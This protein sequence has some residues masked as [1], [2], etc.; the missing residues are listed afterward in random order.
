MQ[1]SGTSWLVFG[2][3][4]DQP[5]VLKVLRAPG[6]EWLAGNVIAAF[7]GRGMVRV[8]DCA[9][10]A[11]LLEEINPGVPLV[12]LTAAGRDDE[13]CVVFAQVLSSMAPDPAPAQVPTAAD[14]GRGFERHAATVDTQIPPDLLSQAQEVY[15]SLV[16]TQKGPRL[17]HGDLHHENI[18]LDA[19]RGWLAV[20]PKGVIG[21]LEFELG[22]WL[23]NPLGYPDLFT[24][25]SAIDR[26]LE[27]LCARLPIDPSRTLGWA[28]AQ[29]I[30]SAIWTVEDEGAIR[31]DHAGL[32]LAGTLRGRF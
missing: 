21:E 1:E 4:R 25:P 31:P 32:A 18:L 9:E 2:R 6:D 11:M 7:R 16:A 14:W 5:V 8:L 19:A 10:G 23:R 13:A 22:A 20:D 15:A 27:R 29:G 30:L 24:Q 17:L 3:R 12:D 26:R 28:F